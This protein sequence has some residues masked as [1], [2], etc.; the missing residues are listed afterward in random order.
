VPV[1]RFIDA[2]A[3]EPELTD[4]RVVKLAQFLFAHLE[5][6]PE[7]ASIFHFYHHGDEFFGR[8]RRMPKA[9]DRYAQTRR[10]MGPDDEIF[11]AHLTDIYR[12]S[13]RNVL[14]NLQAAVLEKLTQ[15]FVSG[16][17]PA[18]PVIL[19]S[20]CHI[21]IDGVKSRK[22]L[23]VTAW[24]AVRQI[25]EFHECKTNLQLAFK[26][27]RIANT[28]EKLDFIQELVVTTLPGSAGAI[29]SLWSTAAMLALLRPWPGILAIG[30][31]ALAAGRLKQAHC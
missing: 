13:R 25:G 24:N 27:E 19:G 15:L 20:N 8:R 1:I 5:F 22:T 23:D 17:Y 10:A 14:R 11:L 21:E 16:K 7:L 31:D 29:I 2:R 4:P 26:P 9:R 3:L 28:R 18:P 12:E 6:I 30:D